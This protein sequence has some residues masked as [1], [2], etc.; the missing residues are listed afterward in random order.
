[1]TAP[2]Q[3][4]VNGSPTRAA[5]IQVRHVLDGTV[6]HI[7]IPDVSN[8]RAETYATLN[9]RADKVSLSTSYQILTLEYCRQSPSISPA[10]RSQSCQ[11]LSSGT[12]TR[13]E[14]FLLVPRPQ[15]EWERRRCCLKVQLLRGLP[16]C[17][18]SLAVT[19]MNLSR[20]Q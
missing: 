11:G 15:G 10:R 18:K 13:E 8:Q 5:H 12:R 7:W 19:L 3:S 4:T 16:H 1:M 6:I 17:T 20:Y 9:L 2:A 14:C